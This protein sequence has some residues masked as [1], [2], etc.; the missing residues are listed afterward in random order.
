MPLN[1]VDLAGFV[2]RFY[3]ELSGGEQQRVQFA[4]VLCQVW[5]PVSARG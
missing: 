3:Q 1:L 4:R 5:E 2:G